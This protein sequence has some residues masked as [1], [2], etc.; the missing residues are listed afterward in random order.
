MFKEVPSVQP[1]RGGWAEGRRCWFHHARRSSV[2]ILRPILWCCLRPLEDSTVFEGIILCLQKHLHKAED[3]YHLQP[4][5]A[6]VS[7][8]GESGPGLAH[9]PCTEPIGR[10]IPGAAAG[11]GQDLLTPAPPPRSPLGSGPSGG[12]ISKA[13]RIQKSDYRPSLDQSTSLFWAS[14]AFS[15][16]HLSGPSH[17]MH[18]LLLGVPRLPDESQLWFLPHLPK[19]VILQWQ[20]LW[21]EIMSPLDF[22]A[23]PGSGNCQAP[24]NLAQCPHLPP[25]PPSLSAPSH[26][27]FGSL[28]RD[29]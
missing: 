18:C 14:A 17:L 12:L 20:C 19:V 7:P 26:P 6:K 29:K 11:R 1:S 3:G 8:R 2:L 10:A 22:W 25:K 5:R 23:A 9:A 13:A 16:A 15:P 24:W 4:G 28:V 21:G 27:P